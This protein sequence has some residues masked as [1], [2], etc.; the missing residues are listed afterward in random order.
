M[1]LKSILNVSFSSEWTRGTRGEKRDQEEVNSEGEM[2]LCAELG[3]ERGPPTHL[4]CALC[5]PCSCLAQWKWHW[6]SRSSGSER[7]ALWT[8]QGPVVSPA[9]WPSGHLAGDI[10]C[11]LILWH[12]PAPTWRDSRCIILSVTVTILFL[13]SHGN[14]IKQWEIYYQNQ[15]V[16]DSSAF[17]MTLGRYDFSL[18]LWNYS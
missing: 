12:W 16:K 6:W 5:R 13:K 10:L 1:K 17:A 14:P 18:S 4:S 9:S 15:Q 8:L 2:V 7:M 3:R 11:C